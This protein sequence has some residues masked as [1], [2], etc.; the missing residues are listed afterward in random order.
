MR[1]IVTVCLGVGWQIWD[2]ATLVFRVASEQLMQLFE[3]VETSFDTVLF[4]GLV[5]VADLVLC[6]YFIICCRT[7]PGLL[8][9]KTRN[10]DDN[11]VLGHRDPS[12]AQIV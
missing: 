4:L 8:R 1:E 6:F 5:E 9:M 7:R 12:V 2:G 3:I 11:V 10:S